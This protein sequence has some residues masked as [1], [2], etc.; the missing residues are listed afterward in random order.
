M[1]NDIRD[2]FLSEISYRLKPIDPLLLVADKDKKKMRQS[3]YSSVEDVLREGRDY[4]NDPY[5][6]WEYPAG[7]K[8][9]LIRLISGR[10]PV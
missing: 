1:R 8:P 5:D 10:P 7:G 3:V 9:L 6:L 4:C 2:E